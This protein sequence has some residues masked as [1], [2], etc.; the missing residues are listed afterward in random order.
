MSKRAGSVTSSSSG[1]PSAHSPAELE[2][3]LSPDVVGLHVD[4]E[5]PGPVKPWADA[6][7]VKGFSCVLL[8]AFIWVVSSYWV[9]DLE[10]KGMTPLLVTSLANSMFTVLLPVCLVRDWI[11]RRSKRRR[12]ARDEKELLISGGQNGSSAPVEGFGD[13]RADPAV[14]EEEDRAKKR[15][16]RRRVFLLALSVWPIWFTCL[17][18]YNWSF[19]LTS[20]MSNTILSIGGTSLFTYFLELRVMRASF[21]WTKFAAIGFCILGTSLWCVGNFEGG[22]DDKKS[23]NALLG[24][25]LCLISSCLY[26]VVSILIGKYLPDSGEAEMAFFWGCTGLINLTVMMPLN[27]VLCLAGKNDIQDLPARLYGMVM[28]KGLMDNL[29]SNY[30]WAYAVLFIGPTSAN[31]GMSI[32]TPMVV[33]IDLVTRNASYLSNP[34]STALNV[35]GALTIMIGFFG[36]SL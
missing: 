5:G 23:K 7:K 9:Q 14:D 2:G 16:S 25:F 35:I 36:L 8:A 4:D 31:V 17:Y 33:I 26:A 15:A 3:G 19:L 22:D 13:D 29:L 24:N 1:E 12:G 34:R 28:L 27:L 21:S 20:V 10:G 11:S 6:K 18:I 30:M 32:E